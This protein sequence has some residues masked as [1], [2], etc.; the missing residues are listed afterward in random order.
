MIKSNQADLNTIMS[1]I[2]SSV[3]EQNQ[4]T[5]QV[6]EYLVNKPYYCIN[7]EIYLL[8]SIKKYFIDKS[9]YKPSI[10][11]YIS[12]SFMISSSR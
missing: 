11:F 8:T 10:K 2:Q 1:S 3:V 4:I 12:T 5:Y 7:I 6:I 9:E